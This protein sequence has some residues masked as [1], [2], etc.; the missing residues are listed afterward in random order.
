MTKVYDRVVSFVNV[1][2]TAFFMLA[3]WYLR[4]PATAKRG[5]A[6]G[7][8]ATLLAVGSVVANPDLVS[9]YGLVTAAVLPAALA[10]V[11]LAKYTPMTGAAA[12]AGREGKVRS[13]CS[14]SSGRGPARW[15]ACGAACVCSDASVR[16][17]A[18]GMPQMVGLL[19]SFGGL[20]A[21]LSSIAVYRV[22]AAAHAR[23]RLARAL[24]RDVV[25][26]AA[27]ARVLLACAAACCRVRST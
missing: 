18:A 6:F 12:R 22:R 7:V 4:T 5:N 21:A 3:I 16:A 25:C 26:A 9:N 17:L 20:A 13:V 27:H 11:L 19:N 24:Q 14:D 10:G 15:Q 8:L 1:P 2:A 23:A